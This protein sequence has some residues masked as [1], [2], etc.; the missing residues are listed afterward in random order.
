MGLPQSVIAVCGMV[1][2]QAPSTAGNE[3]ITGYDVHI[4]LNQLNQTLLISKKSNQFYH[5]FFQDGLFLYNSNQNFTAL[6][7]VGYKILRQQC[8]SSLRFAFVINQFSKYI[9]VLF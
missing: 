2:W 1:A 5:H 4:T 3:L 8:H 6:I 7:K 9:K